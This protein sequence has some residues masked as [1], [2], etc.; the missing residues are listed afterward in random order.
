M[1]RI[2]IA[3]TSLL[4][5]SGSSNAA[6]IDEMP[7]AEIVTIKDC[8]TQPA[9][10]PCEGRDAIFFV[11]GIFGGVD[12]FTNGSYK[13]PQELALEFPDIDIFVIKYNTQLLT[14]V[15]SKVS[16]FDQISEVLMSRM[17]GPVLPAE[18]V[19]LLPE[20]WVNKRGYR[21]VG[22]IAHSLGGNVTTAYIHSVKTELGHIARSQNAYII[23]LGTPA[24]GAYIA[25]VGQIIKRYLGAQEDPL[26]ESLRQ[27]NLFLRMLDV[28]RRAEDGKSIRF[29]CRPLNLFVAIEGAS[30]YGIPV[31]P[32]QSARKPYEN[33]AKEIKIFPTY[34]HLRIAAPDRKEDPLNEWVVDIIR[35]ERTRISQWTK[36]LCNAPY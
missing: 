22:F 14:W 13:W 32:A 6:P 30:V 17:Q 29:Q 9:T 36:P 18:R 23:T 24:D 16:T 4:F 1:R 33:L 12:S 2:L 34:D 27:D 35:N 10:R 15:R 26:L 7:A 20:G 19:R 8:D 5:L 11:H 31:V 28:W 25:N 21:S 3:V